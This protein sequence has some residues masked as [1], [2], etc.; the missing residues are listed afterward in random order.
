MQQEKYI[1]AERKRERERANKLYSQ[2]ENIVMN[3]LS[4]Y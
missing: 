2:L 4:Y 1:G 3:I